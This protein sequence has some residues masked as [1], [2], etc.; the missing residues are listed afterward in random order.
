MCIICYICFYDLVLTPELLFSFSY[1]LVLCVK[2]ELLKLDT[3][4]KFA[5]K[6][7]IPAK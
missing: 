5:K 1:V 3:I 6:K 4:Y 2:L 7:K